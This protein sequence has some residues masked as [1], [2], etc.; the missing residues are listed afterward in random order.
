MYFS[1]W[2]DSNRIKISSKHFSEVW[3]FPYFTILKKITY[4]PTTTNSNFQVFHLEFF[5]TFGLLVGFYV[6][7]AY[8]VLEGVDCVGYLIDRGPV[9]QLQP[10]TTVDYPGFRFIVAIF[11]GIKL[12]D[13]SIVMLYTT[14]LFV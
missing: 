14:D 6:N 1:Y 7:P 13:Y 4:F 10:R 8:F 12:L 3:N 5:L 9:D 2:I 11:W